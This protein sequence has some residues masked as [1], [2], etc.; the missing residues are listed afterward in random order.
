M[1]WGK[2]QTKNADYYGWEYTLKCRF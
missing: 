1:Q 2:G